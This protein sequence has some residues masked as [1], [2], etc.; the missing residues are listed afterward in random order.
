LNGTRSFELVLVVILPAHIKI[1][2]ENGNKAKERTEQH[3]ERGGGFYSKIKPV[4]NK[5][6]LFYIPSVAGKMH[7]AYKGSF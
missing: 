1:T 2:S 7:P 3:G 4:F 6:V 5:R